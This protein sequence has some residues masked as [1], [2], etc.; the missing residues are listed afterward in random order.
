MIKKL[1]SIISLLGQWNYLLVFLGAFLESAAF[2]GFIIPGE[3]IVVLSGV[4]AFQGY[5]DLG[6]CIVVVAS[7]AVLGDTVGYAVGKAVG[8]GYFEKHKKLLFLKK[9][10]I[11]RADAYFRRH[12]GKT[13]FLGRFASFLRAMVPFTAG[14]SRMPYRRFLVYNVAGGITWA[15]IYTL[16]GYFFGQSWQLIEKWT[17]RAGL[18]IFF[19]IILV[20]GSGCLYK[21]IVKRQEGLYRWFGEKYTGIVSLPP[22]RGFIERHPRVVIFIRDRLS[23]GEYLGLHL[24]IGLILSVI[25]VW[26]F[27]GITED[28]L[29]GDPLV[30]VDQWVLHNVRYFRTPAVTDLMVAFS[31][32]GRGAF[33][34]AGSLAV[35]AYF[36]VK[37]RF[38]SLVTYSSAILGGSLLVFILKTAIHRVRPM[39]DHALVKVGGWSFPSGHAM[40]SVIYYGMIAYFVIRGAHSWRL[41]VFV[42]IAA[43]FLIFLVGLSRIYLQAHY[44]SDVLAGYAGGLFWLSMCITGLEIYKKKRNMPL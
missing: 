15:V 25:F 12:G 20:A 19:I 4:L 13:V 7:G 18:F 35:T 22:V 40:M 16:L 3:T 34:T 2:M 33:I 37:R 11:E 17:G 21:I 39:P 38:D 28:V 9:K 27:G 10:H 42:V 44:L 41:R 30:A 5:L 29:T 26:A 32:L 14:I 24:T 6:D 8:R 36:S 31:Q 23:P 43:W 1:F